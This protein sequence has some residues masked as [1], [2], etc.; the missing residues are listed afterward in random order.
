VTAV[1]IDFASI[2]ARFTVAAALQLKLESVALKNITLPLTRRAE[3]GRVIELA[4]REIPIV[5]FYNEAVTLVLPPSERG[6]LTPMVPTSFAEE[7]LA[8]GLDLVSGLGEIRAPFLADAEHS[9]FPRL[10]DQLNQSLAI[11]EVSILRFATPSP[12]MFDPDPRRASDLFG[13]AAL[14]FR[15]LAEASA[16]GGAIAQLTTQLQESLAITA[17]PPDGLTGAGPGAGEP[18]SGEPAR[19]LPDTLDTVAFELAG[20][21]LFLG[22]LPGFLQALFE[23]VQI[24]LQ[25]WVLTEFGAIEALVLD[26]RRTA[27]ATMFAGLTGT[28]DRGEHLV[29]AALTVVGG[30]LLFTIQVY[31]TMATDLGAGVRKFVLGLGDFLLDI[32]RLIQ[33]LPELMTALTGFNLISL[34]GVLPMVALPPVSIGDLLDED[35]QNVNVELRDRLFD[36]ITAAEL[37]VKAAGQANGTSPLILRAIRAV[38][39]AR[40][41][42]GAL[43]D[44]NPA[45]PG[46]GPALPAF[47]E[48]VAL[49]F[50]SDFPDLWAPLF[51]E[52]RDKQ[53]VEMVESLERALRLTVFHGILRVQSG[54]GK[55]DA[56]MSLRAARSAELSPASSDVL[57]GLPGQADRLTAIAFGPGDLSDAGNPATSGF[58]PLARAFESWLLVGG[59]E[60]VGRVID[61]FVGELATQWEARIA[62]GTE[63]TMPLTPTSPHRLFAHA[64]LGRVVMPRLTVQVAAGRALDDDLATEVAREFTVAVQDA[65]ATGQN[66]LREMAV[67]ASK[68]GD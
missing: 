44:P 68:G 30:N 8:G 48:A 55:I 50:R 25:Q 4:G 18:G 1:P 43:F 17:G 21:T 11:I 7:L 52:G 32:V 22:L 13:L 39:Q 54:L 31:R 19:S 12:R 67:L 45:A 29:R 9:S 51:G 34:G 15:A 38:E 37:A 49:H 60:T 46:G 65:F 42:V 2:A 66:R 41:L 36:V 14:A 33:S 61:S 27:F 5:A 35:G 6:L 40:I 47:P 57:I 64:V 24:R 3:A 28:A 53:V 16:Q 56:E 63:L 20:G 62:T 26:F 10:V 59:F 23:G 58:D